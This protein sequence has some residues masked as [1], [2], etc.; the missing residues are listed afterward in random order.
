MPTYWRGFI[1]N[2]CWILSKPFSA[3]I[4]I[5][6]CFLYFN[7]LIRCI[8][9]TDLHILKNPCIFGITPTGSW[10]I[11]ILLMCYWI[12]IASILL[13][14]FKSMFTSDNW[15]ITFMVISSSDWYQGDGGIVEGVW[16]FCSCCNFSEEF[17]GIGVQFSSVSQSCPNLCDCMDCSMSS[18]PDHRQLLEFT[19]THV[20]WVSDVI[21]PCNPL[22]SL[23]LLPSI[24]PSIRVFSNES[25]LHIRWPKYWSFSFS[26]S[27]STEYSGL[28]SFRMDWLDFLAVQGTLNSLLQHHSSRATIL[29][30][31]AFHIVQISHA[32]MTTGKMIALTRQTYVGK[33]MS[34]LFNMWSRL[35]IA[36]FF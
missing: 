23:L 21:Q 12:W 27:P 11:I 34:L 9:L 19:Q 35:V 31:L 14:I 24:F 26:I 6:I 32:Y 7:L 17:E 18:L 25:T 20:H 1:I 16:E 30:R 3:S 22:S 13:K 33:I 5:I 4:E 15:R 2:G 10:Y 36:S 8:T 29:R 28:T